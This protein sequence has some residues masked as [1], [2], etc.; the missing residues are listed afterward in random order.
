MEIYLESEE[1]AAYALRS[2]YRKYGYKPYK[3]SKFE[4]YDFYV[5]NKNFL[6]SDDIITFTD[7][8][9]K[10][11]AL[12][13]DV[14]LSIVKNSVGGEEIEKVYYNE[15]VFRVSDESKAFK[16]IMQTGLECI[17]KLDDYCVA[18]VLLL[19]KK[20]LETLSPEYV[21][22]V[23][24]VG[25]LSDVI[26]DTGIRGEGK[27]KLLS[28]VKEKNLH[29]VDEVFLR[30]GVSLD[31][32]ETLKELIRTD[33]TPAEI[34]PKLEKMF[35]GTATEKAVKKFAAVLS[36]IPQDR[37]RIDFSVLNDMRYY[38]GIVF[39]GFISGMPSGVLSGGQYDL[40]MKKMGKKSGAIG[41][42]VYPERLTRSAEKGLDADVLVLYDDSVSL[43]KVSDT[44]QA[45]IT[46]G[47]RVLAKKNIGSERIGKIF[48]IR[49]KKE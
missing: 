27:Q 24:H 45:F 4:S 36:L 3:M 32:A 40:L 38:N 42:A 6:L 31:R 11:M 46:E 1:R 22:D 2:L 12:K 49:E 34:L 19:A 39:Q 28:L 21:L 41:F 47:K 8:N 35:A 7:K 25:I 5:R 16:E 18:E 14:T 37:V 48:D 17:G 33:G 26:E 10:L 13:P 15:N 29:E 20:S 43:K 9:G 44:V 30:S 23:S